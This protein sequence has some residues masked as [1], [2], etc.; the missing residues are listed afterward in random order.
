MTATAFEPNTDSRTTTLLRF[1]TAGSVDDGKSTLVGRLLYD[2]KSILADAYEA[3][4]DADALLILTDWAEFGELDLKRLN[5]ALRYP[6]IVDGRNMYDPN[7]MSEHGF[8]YLSVGR[9]AANPVR[10][11]VSSN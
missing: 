5:Q 6:I 1:A 8:T 2:T 7:E 11:L 4:E 3:A 10:D 9:P